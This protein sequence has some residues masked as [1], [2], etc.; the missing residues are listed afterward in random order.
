MKAPFIKD[1]TKA[2]QQPIEC[3]THNESSNEN[4]EHDNDNN[5]HHYNTLTHIST[6]PT[7]CVNENNNT[8]NYIELDRQ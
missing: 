1:T 8:N 7:E 4:N 5:N 3:I 2:Y 6:K